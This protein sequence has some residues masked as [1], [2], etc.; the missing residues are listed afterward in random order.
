MGARYNHEKR[1]GTGSFIFDAIGATYQMTD[2]AQA[3]LEL[4]NTSVAGQDFSRITL[5]A[6]VG[7]YRHRR[8]SRFRNENCDDFK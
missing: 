2:P 4:A 3:M 7:L 1:D 5:N 8:K 6:D